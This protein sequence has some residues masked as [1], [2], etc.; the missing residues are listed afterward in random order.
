MKTS[1]KKQTLLL[2]T[3]VVALLA[4]ACS[5]DEDLETTITDGAER[6]V[7]KTEFSLSFP[8]TIGI[9]TRM[10]AGTVQEGTS[11]T[12]F[13]GIQNMVLV[14]FSEGSI[15]GTTTK[16]GDNITLP[17]TNIALYTDFTANHA[18]N[19]NHSKVYTNVAVPIGTK[20]FLFYGKA[21]KAGSDETDHF[22]YGNVAVKQTTGVP[23]TTTILTQPNFSSTP[24]ELSFAPV[25]IVS[26]N[27]AGTNG[28]NLASYLSA[29]ASAHYTDA[30]SVVQYWSGTQSMAMR[31]LLDELMTSHAGSS[32]NV[33]AAMQKIYSLLK[34]NSDALSQAIC[35]A[36]TEHKINNEAAVSVSAGGVL[37]FIEGKGLDNYPSNLPDGSAFI[38]FTPIA[39]SHNGTVSCT[40][41]TSNDNTGLNIPD[42]T[43]YAYPAELYYHGNS[44][45]HVAGQSMS[46]SYTSS[47]SWAQVLEAYTSATGGAANGTVSRT[48]R[49]IAISKPVQYGVGRLDLTVQAYKNSSGVTS[50]DD[51]LGTAIT[52][53][54]GETNL[55]PLTGVLVGGQKAVGW[56]FSTPTGSEYTVYDKSIPEGIALTSAVSAANYTLLFETADAASAEDKVKIALEFQNNSVVTFKGRNGYIYP[57]CRFYLVGE[58]TPYS[59][60][61][62]HYTGKT[63]DENLIKKAFVQDY[64]T[65]VSIQVASL[66]NAYNVLPDLKL[67][68]LELGLS[69]NLEWQQG[70]D[71]TITIQ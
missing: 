24:N 37:S 52:L 48:T 4:A 63:G 30:N 11:S 16:F 38:S 62:T 67:P 20:G 5:S 61:T 8:S 39:D 2:A 1:I 31:S 54:N 34:G 18:D 36:I 25:S 66:A 33:L 27:A 70:I 9:G 29:V 58:L 32:R 47:N 45:I 12:V 3:I 46:S 23:A 22:T 14:P 50:L 40:T 69:V 59:N 7:V 64:K 13:R 53:K 21:T 26:T 43:T 60:N 19:T 68:E 55:F 41:S 35:T 10:G 65:T 49:S 71:Q 44:T 28:N 6:G 15:N 17:A 57:N 51:A 56:N 42:L